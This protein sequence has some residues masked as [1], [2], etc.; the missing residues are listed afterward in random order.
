MVCFDPTG[1]RRFPARFW[2]RF[3][4]IRRTR[5]AFAPLFMKRAREEFPGFSGYRNELACPINRGSGLIALP[6]IRLDPPFVAQA[7]QFVG[8]ILLPFPD[9]H[10]FPPVN[11]PG[12]E[13]SST[14]RSSGKEALH[15]HRPPKGKVRMFRRSFYCS[16]Y[17][18]RNAFA[19]NSVVIR[20]SKAITSEMR[21]FTEERRN[22]YSFRLP[23]FIDPCIFGT[24]P[25]G[26]QTR[27]DE[28][29]KDGE[30]VAGAF[31]TAVKQS[32]VLRWH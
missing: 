31:L 12:L 24:G 23:P 25:A 20:F 18:M 19:G 16:S 11:Q 8:G 27:S 4:V 5:R 22:N 15:S 32:V 26:A 17:R 9:L 29:C 7:L 3:A 21:T 13:K 30:V 10:N 6:A 2:R 1:H 14:D 28:S